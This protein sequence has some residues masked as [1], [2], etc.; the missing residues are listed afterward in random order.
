MTAYIAR[1]SVHAP[2]MVRAAVMMATPVNFAK[3]AP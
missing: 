2:R 1:V 3:L